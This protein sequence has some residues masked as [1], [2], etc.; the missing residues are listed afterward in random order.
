[1]ESWKKTL[2]IMWLAQFSSLMG[3]SFVLPFMPFYVRDLG[4]Q[5]DA[6]VAWWAGIASAATSFTLAIF[7]PIWGHYADRY[8]RK[9]MVL[10]SMFGGAI[11][12]LLTGY[13]RNVTELCILRALQGAVTGTMTASVALVASTTPSDR[14]GYALGL[15][16]AAVFAGSSVGPYLGG[17]IWDMRDVLGPQAPFLVASCA[18]V[19]SGLLVKFG[20]KEQFRRHTSREKGHQGSF[21]EVF[22]ASGFLVAVLVLFQIQFGTMARQPVFVLFIEKLYGTHEG[23]AT[24]V[25]QLLAVTGVVAALSAGVF[26]RFSDRLGHKRL[27]AYSTL[28]AGVVVLPQA[29][30]RNVWQLAALQVIFGF[31]VAGIG[32]SA[33]AIIRNAISDRN[34]AKAYGVSASL[35]SLGSGLGPLV[36]GYLAGPAGLGLRA[37]FLVTGVVLIMTA[38]VASIALK[39]PTPTGD[40]AE[41]R[42]D[43]APT[44]T[45]PAAAAD[46]EEGSPSA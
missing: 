10:R 31:A 42:V 26:G 11:V 6:N 41:P 30:A 1:M 40:L 17:K 4:V 27:L 33:N 24:F 46:P 25:G 13:A 32:P 7:S 3:F 22:A 20:V 16:Q 29:V 18:L 38:G 28:V 39:S 44:I 9:V 37:P 21:A 45:L 15:M 35:T 14:S 23:V 43:I 8:G 12:L 36:G 2:Y 19:A 5:G 34:I